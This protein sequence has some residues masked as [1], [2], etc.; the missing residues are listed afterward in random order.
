MSL[1]RIWRKLLEGG[2]IKYFKEIRM[3]DAEEV[4]LKEME[5]Q[6][7]YVAGFR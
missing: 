1:S 3:V 2:F 7:E 5:K 4:E 6:L